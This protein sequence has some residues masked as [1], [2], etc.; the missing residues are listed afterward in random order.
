MCV[1][2]SILGASPRLLGV[3]VTHYDKR[4]TRKEDTRSCF[5]LISSCGAVYTFTFR[6]V[7]DAPTGVSRK[8][9]VYI[10][11][12]YFFPRLVSCGACLQLLACTAVRGKCATLDPLPTYLGVLDVL[13]QRG[14]GRP[15]RPRE[16]LEEHVTSPL[17]VARGYQADAAA[18][19][20]RVAGR[21][22][23]F[24]S[25]IFGCIYICSLRLIKC[26]RARLTAEGVRASWD[27]NVM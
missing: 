24:Y 22:G 14:R 23:R 25:I 1:P 4:V 27:Q 7:I 10:I 15:R 2:P 26:G 21:W 12:S 17:V 6:C 13:Q 20:G 8:R 5:P 18:A 11:H 9:K 16:H 3:C 19:T